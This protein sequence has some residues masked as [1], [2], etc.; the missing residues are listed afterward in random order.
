MYCKYGLDGVR[1]VWGM[2][3]HRSFEDMTVLTCTVFLHVASISP[4]RALSA[5]M[6]FGRA[7]AESS[8]PLLPD[9]ASA[10]AG[11]AQSIATTLGQRAVVRVP[12]HVT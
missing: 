12:V 11:A 6:L 2:R 10:S 3:V 8:V 5:R 4:K 9:A 7:T 1:R